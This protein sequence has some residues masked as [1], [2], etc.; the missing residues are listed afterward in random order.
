MKKKYDIDAVIIDYLQLIK[1]S[2]NT[3]SR[4]QE[5]AYISQSIKNDIAKS[6]DIPVIL[7]AQL[8]RQTESRKESRPQ[9]SDLRESGSIE[10][11]ADNIILLHRPEYYDHNT[12]N[13]P[14]QRTELIV[15]KG[16]NCGTGIANASFYLD[17]NKFSNI[18]YNE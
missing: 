14:I 11:D 4:E 12:M 18:N 2:N 16:R 3:R 10:N 8:S 15:A 1:Y 9:M 5:V 7:L 6:I 17:T 13:S